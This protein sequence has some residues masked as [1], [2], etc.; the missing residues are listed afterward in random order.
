MS[1][2]MHTT[3]KTVP[4]SPL[5]LSLNIE[6]VDILFPCFSLNDFA[7]LCGSSAVQSII[8]L[9]C[10]RAQLPFQLGGLESNVLFVDG[11]NSF[12]LYDISSIAQSFE[13]D[14]KHVLERIFISRAFTAHQMTDLILE[15]LENATTTYDTK[16]VIL[17]NPA[18]LY[19]D[20][21]IPKQESHEIFLQL[22]HY[23]ADFAKRHQV[24]LIAT[25]HPHYYS[26]NYYS[27]KSSFFNQVLCTRADIVASIKKIN[28]RPQFILEKHTSF[29][30]GKAELPSPE[31]TLVDFLEA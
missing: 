25:H 15:Q 12:R 19:M 16:I 30:L 1:I 5:R 4:S 23:L 6:T 14:P 22:T 10:V 13:L 24:I 28:K 26:K 8:N 7:V 3:L 21:D 29:D 9:L 2:E 11:S 27:K 20:K 17:A 18:Q 31:P